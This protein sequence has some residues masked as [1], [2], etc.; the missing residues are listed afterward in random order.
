MPVTGYPQQKGRGSARSPRLIQGYANKIH[1]V[2]FE[3]L[4]HS[5]YSNL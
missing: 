1:T 4:L 5:A 2:I 3:L